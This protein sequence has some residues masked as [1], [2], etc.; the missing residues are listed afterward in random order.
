MG[1]EGETENLKK[2]K[3]NQTNLGGKSWEENLG[4]RME[5]RKGF[6]INLFA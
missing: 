5:T 3:K 1:E 6:F 4:Y 2:K